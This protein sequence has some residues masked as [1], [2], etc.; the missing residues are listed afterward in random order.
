MEQSSPT[1]SVKFSAF[2][3]VQRLVSALKHIATEPYSE[4]DESSPQPSL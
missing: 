4:T 1:L 3:R 2:F